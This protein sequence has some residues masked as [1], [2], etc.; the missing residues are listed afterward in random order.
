MIPYGR[1][2]IRQEDIDA[3]I[4]VLKSDFL[5]QG[6]KVKEFEDRFAAYVGAKYAVAVANGTAALHLCTLALNVRPGQTVLTTPNTFVASANCV[7]YCGGDVEFIDIDEKTYCMDVSLL[8]KKLSQSPKKYSG[9][10]AVDFAGYPM[11]MEKVRALADEHGLWV[12]EDACHAPGA[13]RKNGAGKKILAGEG[14]YADLAIF[15]FHPVK[16]IACGEGGMITTNNYDLYQSLLKL[17][18]HGITKEPAS[19]S[20]NEGGWFYEMQTLGFNY[21]IPDMLC[22]LGTSQL[23]RA[24]SSLERRQEI[25]KRYLKEL[26]DLPVVLPETSEETRHAYHLF[27]IKTERRKELY[28]FLKLKDIHPQVHYIPVHKQP[29]YVSKYGQQTLEKSESYYSQCL[30]LPIYQSM[31]DDEQT[32]VIKSI[33]EFYGR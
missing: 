28:D 32:Y 23:R 16:H 1:Q 11:D 22:A 5:T 26:K 13:W 14:V 7:L 31:T 9:I 18:T 8:P 29:F 19:L 3:V 2:D 17:R 6:P 33:R 15:S 25:A 20:V 24:G 4:D 30:S 27:V 10:V 12:I 21:R